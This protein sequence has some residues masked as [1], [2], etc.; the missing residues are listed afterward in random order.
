MKFIKKP[1]EI[2]AL[3]WVGFNEEHLKTFTEGNFRRIESPVD[4]YTAEIYDEIHNTWV[5]MKLTDWVIKGVQG[6]FYPCDNEVLRE[7]YE[8]SDGDIFNPM[9][10]QKKS[11]RS[12]FNFNVDVE[13]D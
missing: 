7:T 10:G 2:E 6:E 1:V 9:W 5:K 12:V 4:E 11:T 13:S 8:P 3:Q